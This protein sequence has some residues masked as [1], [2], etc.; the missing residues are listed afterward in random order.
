MEVLRNSI[1]T[2]AEKLTAIQYDGNPLYFK[3]GAKGREHTIQDNKYHLN[4]LLTS[5]TLE[6]PQIFSDYIAWAK[7]F[8]KSIK[9]PDNMLEEN[10]EL[11]KK[12]NSEYF[13]IEA[14]SKINSY[15]D[16]ALKSLDDLPDEVPSF[17]KPESK[18]DNLAAEY[19]NRLLRNERSEASRLILN[20]VG[21]DK[22]KLKDIYL[23]VFE[24][25]QKEVG[26][27]WQ[28]NIISV[29]QEHYCT[30]VT[31]LVMSQL[32]PLIFEHERIG[33]KM[34]ATSVS[35]ELHEIGIRM[36]SDFFEM[37]GWDTYFYGANTPVKDLINAVKEMNPDLVAVSTTIPTNLDSAI[38]I[39]N[40]IKGSTEQNGVKIMV[41]GYP[42]NK[43]KELWKKV[44]ADCF[45]S[46][47][48]SAVNR[49][50]ELFKNLK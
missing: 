4:Y 35:G 30:A 23:Y 39:I 28:Q 42:F 36:V 41:G 13:E 3:Y 48:Q 25:T 26:R 20:E 2:L 18:Y 5:V 46:D 8:F 12:V 38:T 11:I 22:S 40:S 6:N 7:V 21:D 16:S 15:I 49:A 34:I 47:A 14:A 27:L 32:Y 33:K 50:R 24:V 1:D 44:G 19:L 10:L 43:D 37:E 17:I 29:A 31:Q 45:A 9:L